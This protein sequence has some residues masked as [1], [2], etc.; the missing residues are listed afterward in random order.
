MADHSLNLGEYI[1]PRSGR[2]SYVHCDV[3]RLISLREEGD[4]ALAG[5]SRPRAGECVFCSRVYDLAFSSAIAPKLH[6][7]SVACNQGACYAQRQTA[8]P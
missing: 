5:A 1:R 2:S 4:A 7:L 8:V 3:K 6:N